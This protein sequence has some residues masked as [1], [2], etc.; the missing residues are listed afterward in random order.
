[1][2]LAQFVADTLVVT[3]YLRERFATDRIYLMA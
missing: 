2:T 1:M 3:D